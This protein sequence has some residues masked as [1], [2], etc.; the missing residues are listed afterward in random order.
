M[1]VLDTHRSYF[2][3]DNPDAAACFLNIFF[4]L[5]EIRRRDME[6]QLATRPHTVAELKAAHVQAT[7]DLERLANQYVRETNLGQN[8]TALRRWNQVVLGQLGIDNF[9]LFRQ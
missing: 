7:R 6:R 2:A 8:R 9:R 3:S 1:T 4:D 5:C